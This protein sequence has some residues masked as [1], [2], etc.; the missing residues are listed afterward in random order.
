MEVGTVRGVGFHVH[1][2]RVTRKLPQNV[3]F[4]VNRTVRSVPRIFGG[5]LR[6]SIF[7]CRY[8]GYDTN[9]TSAIYGDRETFQVYMLINRYGY[10]SWIITCLHRITRPR[11]FCVWRVC[12]PY[13]TYIYTNPLS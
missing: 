11:T 6:R 1:D 9:T 4:I 13:I 2:E 10:I 12:T 7:Q 3:E 8:E 5:G